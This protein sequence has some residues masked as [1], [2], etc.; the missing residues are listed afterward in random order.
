MNAFEEFLAGNT[1]ITLSNG[2]RVSIPSLTWGNELK[3]YNL[4]TEIFSKLSFK[5]DESGVPVFDNSQT[6]AFL[7]TFANEITQIAAII[8]GKDR[9]WVEA[10]LSSTDIVEF[11]LPLSLNIYGKINK[12]MTDAVSLLSNELAPEEEV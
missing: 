2:D 8:F 1:E 12:G 10:T 6:Q 7:T 3:I 5:V 4:L 11:V 9:K